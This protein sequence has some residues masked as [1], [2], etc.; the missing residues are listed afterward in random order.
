MIGTALR[1]TGLDHV[2]F[3]VL[4]VER[5]RSF[6]MRLFGM[7]IDHERPGQVFLRCG[8]KR[9]LALFEHQDGAEIHGGSE[10]NHLALRLESGDF[11]TVK[12]ALEA[13]GI[14]FRGRRGDPE[15]VYLEDPDGHRLQ[16]IYPDRQRRHQ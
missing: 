13:E 15:C 4:D 3:H 7:E 12:A 6:Y 8:E 1:V 14:P 16:L 10:V 11:A 9:V 2:V 5:S